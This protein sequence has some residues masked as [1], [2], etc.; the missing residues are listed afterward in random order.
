[1]LD[2]WSAPIIAAYLGLVVVWY[3]RGQIFR[4]ILEFIRFVTLCYSSQFN[5]FH[6]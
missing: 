4:A 5:N 3:E 2:G 6:A 1:M